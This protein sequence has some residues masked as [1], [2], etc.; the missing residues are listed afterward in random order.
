[1]RLTADA[2]GAVVE[3]A[4]DGVGGADPAAGSG[5]RGLADRVE[6]VGG[7]LLFRPAAGR[8]HRGAAADRSRTER[9]SMYLTAD[10]PPLHASS[11]S[12]HASPAF[13]YGILHSSGGRAVAVDQP[14][15][16]RGDGEPDRSAVGREPRV[17]AE[18]TADHEGERQPDRN[19]P[20]SQRR[21]PVEHPAECEQHVAEQAA[22]LQDRGSS[23]R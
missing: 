23:A 3:I 1:M 20:G 6:A 19:R 17:V 18:H 16:E 11:A 22:D 4:D 7:R 2:T 10:S 5:L 21:Q 13:R 14:A 12:T 15:A 8:C 9:N